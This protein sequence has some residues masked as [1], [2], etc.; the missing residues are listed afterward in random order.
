LD[1]RKPSSWKAC[2]PVC[3]SVVK[4]LLPKDQA[5]VNEALK[6]SET[7]LNKVTE[8]TPEAVTA[9]VEKVVEKVVEV[10]KVAEVEKIEITLNVPDK[11]E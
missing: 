11:S 3:L 1:L 8:S 10:E 9:S 5:L 7:V 2:V 6:Y 4:T